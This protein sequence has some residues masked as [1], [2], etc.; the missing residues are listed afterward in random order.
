DR[1]IVAG[2]EQDATPALG[3]REAAEQRRDPCVLSDVAEPRHATGSGREQRPD[4][5]EE[6][7][8]EGMDLF[9]RDARELLEQRALLRGELPG[10]LHQQ[11][12]DLVAAAVAV[13]VGDTFP[14]ELEELTRL[15]AGG[16]L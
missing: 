4:L 2:P 12:D 9:A 15:R 1:R 11:A 7:L 16:D 13:Q 3:A 6:A 5:L 14:L 10:R 8:L